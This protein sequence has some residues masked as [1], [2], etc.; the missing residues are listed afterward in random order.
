MKPC[1][2]RRSPERLAVWARALAAGSIALT[3]MPACAGTDYARDVDIRDSAG[4]IIATNHPSDSV[5]VSEVWT[6]TEDLRIGATDGDD[7]ITF[8]QVGEVAVDGAGNIYV[9]DRQARRV[10][11]YDPD[12]AFLRFIGRAGEG[13]GELSRFP[14]GLMIRDDT[15]LVVADYMRARVSIFDLEGGLLAT[16]PVPA[17]PLG[18]SWTLDDSGD[19]VYRAQTIGRGDGGGFSFWDAIVKMDVEAPGAL[20]TLL[21]MDYPATDLGGPGTLRVPL[22][23]NSPFWDRLDDGRIAWSSLDRDEVR[24]HAPDGRLVLIVRSDAWRKRVASRADGETLRELLRMK[25]TALG[26]VVEAADGP[27][28]VFPDSFPSITAVRAGP[29]NTIWVQRMGSVEAIDPV[30]VNAPGPAEAFGGGTWDVFDAEGAFVGVV[31]MPLRFRTMEVTSDGVYGVLR[32][33][34]DVQRVIRLRLD[35]SEGMF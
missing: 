8:G 18:M 32:D 20:D 34:M 2:T 27:G 21:V 5:D 28:V 1:P 31:R 9:L 6:A 33:E 16:I 3:A 12:G 30:A 10:K 15:A 24:V 7:S 29:A 25:L 13:P 11:V 14:N 26:G 23:V 4:V 35:R 19:L 17:R 22:I